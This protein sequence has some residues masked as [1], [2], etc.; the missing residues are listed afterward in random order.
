[1]GKGGKRAKRV[2]TNG[3]IKA[4]LGPGECWGKGRVNGWEDK[5][6]GPVG[7]PRVKKMILEIA[8]FTLRTQCDTKESLQFDDLHSESRTICG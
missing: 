1:M 4:G 2:R 8:I 7:R 5:G 3:L 6:G